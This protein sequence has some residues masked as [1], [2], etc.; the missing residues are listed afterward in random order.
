MASHALAKGNNNSLMIQ[1]TSSG[2][3]QKSFF[4]VQILIRTLATAFTVAAIS[5]MLTSTQSISLFGYNLVVHYSDTS[6]MRYLFG[7]DIAACVCSVLSLICVFL[8]SRSGSDL[9]HY[10]YLFLHD[11]VIMLLLMSGCA[12]AIAIAYVSKYGEHKVGW[13]AGCDN[14][15]KF[16]NRISISIVLSFLAFFCFLTLTIMSSKKLMSRPIE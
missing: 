15:P 6:A 2:S 9:K 14:V 16:C 7:T 1:G 13:M 3:P 5:I 10:F 8:L 4:T 12:A 11:M